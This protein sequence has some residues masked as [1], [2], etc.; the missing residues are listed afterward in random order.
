MLQIK[1]HLQLN[2]LVHVFEFLVGRNLGPIDNELDQIIQLELLL[3]H[4]TLFLKQ[5]KL[6]RKLLQ[7]Y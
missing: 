1:K 3:I 2:L 6:P 7:Y 5:Q 4:T